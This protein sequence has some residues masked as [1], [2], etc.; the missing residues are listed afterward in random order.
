MAL[1]APVTA[2]RGRAPELD[3]ISE[4]LA[5]VLAGEGS[6][7]FVE[8]RPGYG[9]SRLLEEAVRMAGRLP[10]RVGVATAEPGGS[11]IPLLPLMRALFE[12]ATPLLDRAEVPDLSASPDHLYWLLHEL[13][14]ML[15]T[16]ALAAPLFVC[17][18]DLQW[19]G[20][21]TVAA[22]RALARWLGAVPIVWVA[23]YR[24]G[25]LSPELAAALD[26][27][28]DVGAQRIVLA[29][30]DDDAVRQIAADVMG[31]EPN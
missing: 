5:G 25:Q 10:I 24:P 14:A 16:A 20:K 11:V 29:P 9:K 17:L 21:G 27:L 18:D 4:R 23:A 13:E 22:V 2:L 7:V 30:L 19:A 8:G 28:A 6:I 12:G 15:E 31:A 3:V 26:E 1:A